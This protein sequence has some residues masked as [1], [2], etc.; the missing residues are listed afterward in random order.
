[1]NI[2][3]LPERLRVKGVQIFDPSKIVKVNVSEETMLILEKTNRRLV[4]RKESA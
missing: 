3:E 4:D 1:M 2:E